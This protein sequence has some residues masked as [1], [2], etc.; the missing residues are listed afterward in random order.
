MT[1]IDLSH[2]LDNHAPPYPGDPPVSLEKNRNFASDGFCT[3]VLTACMHAGTHIDAPLHLLPGACRLDSF[4]PDRFVGRGVLLDVR[5]QTVISMCPAYEGL[6]EAG[7]IVLL[8]TGFDRH[9]RTDA[10][11]YFHDHPQVNELFCLFL[12]DRGIS[13]LGFDMPSPD[14]APYH[15]HRLLLRRDILLLENLT[16]LN[17][18]IGVQCFTVMALPLPVPAEAGLTRAVA[19]VNEKA[20]I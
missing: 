9:Y 19:I 17:A 15:C 1:V 12:A 14:H 18:L 16:N 8:Y 5:G 10:V 3:S 11:R 13:M 7:D 6:F 4:P 2:R 20:R